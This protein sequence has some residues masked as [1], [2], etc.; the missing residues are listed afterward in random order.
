MGEIQDLLHD[1][2]F[3]QAPIMVAVLNADFEIVEANG[4]FREVFGPW[5][6]KRCYELLKQRDAP[7]ERCMAAWTF[8]DGKVRAC[9]DR[10]HMGGALT[11]H[12]VVRIA[13]LGSGTRPG[14]P[15]LVWI[16]SNVNEASSLQHENELLFERAPSY[17]TV[18]D[19]DLEIVRANR[20]M[21]ETFGRAWGSRCY[22]VYKRRDRPCRECPALMVFEDGQD[23][24]STQ[25]GMSASGEETHYVVTASPLSREAGDPNGRVNFVIEMATDVTHLHDLE[26]EKLE[27]E[28]MAAVGQTV[29]GLAHGIK[30]VLMGLE[31][32]IYVMQ[33]GLSK[34]ET[35]RVQRGMEM[36][37]RNVEKISALVKNL[38]GFSKGRVPSVALV[39]P[40][41][42]AGEVLELFRETAGKSGIRLAGYLQPGI[43]RAPLD[44]EGIHTCLSNLISNAIDAC[45]TS[46]KPGCE[47]RLKTSEEDG[48]LV[49]E[50]A[51]DGCGMD[52]EV[53]KKI[54]TTFFT[55]KGAG[56]TG[57][58]LLLTR[59]IVQEHGG[60]I[61]VESKEGQGTSF[62]ILLPRERLPK[63]TGPGDD[64]GGSAAGPS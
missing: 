41:A 34:N 43:A 45:Q 37:S 18:L 9:D 63:P 33:S 58:G 21:R 52:Y 6:G 35:A 60:R 27:A 50:V 31:G 16:G 47:V 36:L 20:K 11:S 5:N 13:P 48:V 29:A 51:D 24:T 38:L 17:I 14:P 7:C 25:V 26:K 53:K 30:N 23:H 64:N 59:K 10:L 40:N 55:T 4:R 54:F 3:E 15:Y 8:E 2:L 19:R 42:V 46:E 56:G 22:Q 49:F 39:D 62:R 57:L 61:L 44:A 32:G 28:R 1:H 12:F